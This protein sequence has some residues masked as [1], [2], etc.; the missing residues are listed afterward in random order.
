MEKYIKLRDEL[1]TE[2]IPYKE[3]EYS[4]GHQGLRSFASEA[5]G[6]PTSGSYGRGQGAHGTWGGGRELEFNLGSPALCPHSSSPPRPFPLHLAWRELAGAHPAIIL[7]SPTEVL[8]G[9]R[10]S[11]VLAMWTFQPNEAQGWWMLRSRR[12]GTCW[13]FFKKQLYWDIIH[14][15]PNSPLSMYNSVALI[16]L[17]MCATTTTIHLQNIFVTP[18]ETL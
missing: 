2:E 11:S 14:I 8:T 15:P 13:V 1:F 12:G 17:T 10:A 16:T 3:K 6:H 18:T 7:T 9:A 4:Q 5:L